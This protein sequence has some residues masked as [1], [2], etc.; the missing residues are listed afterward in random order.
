MFLPTTKQELK[1]LGWNKLDIILVTGDAYIDSPFMGIAVIGQVLLNKGY[2]VG[3]IAQP[4][5]ESE[6]D[7]TRLGKPSL[8]WGISG[9][10]IDS[11]VAN[12]TATKKRRKKDDYTPGGIN[13]KRP[14]R[15]VIAYTNLVK[16]YFKSN[17]TPIVL[18]GIE[19]SLRR[20]SHY[21][22]WSN[23]IRR[24]ILFDSKADYLVFGMGE[25]TIV[26]LAEALSKNLDVTN[27]KGLGYISKTSIDNYIEIPSFEEVAIDKEKFIKSFNLFYKNTDSIT[28][29]GIVQKHGNRYLVL[30]PVQQP[31]STNEL[32]AVYN[33]DFQRELHPYHKKDGEAKALITI[34]FSIPAHRGCYGQC[35]F[36]A[37]SIHEGTTVTWRSEE[38]ILKEGLILS[39]LKDFK[40]IIH[41]IG[42]P[43]ANMYGFEC[44][45]KLKK[46]ICQD[47]R[48][49]FPNVCESLNPNH[50]SQANLLEKL[51]KVKGIKKVFISSGI[52]HDLIMNDKK[53][54]HAYISKIVANHVSGQMKLAPEHSCENVLELMGKP[55]VSSVL[56][57]RKDFNKITKKIEKNQFL[58]YYLIAAHPGCTIKDMKQLKEFTKKKLK[59]NP[60]Q[61]QIFT[62]TPSTYSTLMYHTSID[63]FSGSKIFVEK[64]LKGKEK[65]KKIII[66]EN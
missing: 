48:C 38:S 10:A 15:A 35:N 32:D 13:N 14:D 65:Q 8:F 4:D 12:Y 9:G 27:I 11:M 50:S 26:E 60:L 20:I 57:F 33:L 5:M 62:P 31:L 2:K 28:A 55:N 45:K 41:D 42:G 37:I 24:S 23:K 54:G 49:L 47:K 34:K 63:P 22:F 56:D 39:K 66:D 36:C 43:T 21:D 64:D 58:T 19:A 29:K 59:I 53:N 61:V 6:K 3:I 1:K 18:G 17:T 44:K 7:I 16:K 51:L 40:G 30:N 52:R 25:K 46:G